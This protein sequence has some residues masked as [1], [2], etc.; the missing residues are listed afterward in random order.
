MASEFSTSA[1][2]SEEGFRVALCCLAF[3]AVRSGVPRL[4]VVRDLASVALSIWTITKE[5]ARRG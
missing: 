2:T 1:P 4:R 5:E 3:R